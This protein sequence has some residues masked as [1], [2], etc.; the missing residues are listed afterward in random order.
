MI[1]DSM[2]FKKQPI[3]NK[4]DKIINNINCWKMPEVLESYQLSLKSAQIR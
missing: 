1:T 2:A 3:P 4:S